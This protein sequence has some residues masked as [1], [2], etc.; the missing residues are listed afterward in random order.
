MFLKDNEDR[1]KK[2]NEST[3][4]AETLQLEI[5]QVTVTFS[6]LQ[7]M[8]NSSML[9]HHIRYIGIFSNSENRLSL[10]HAQVYGKCL[11]SSHWRLKRHC[12]AKW[13][14]NYM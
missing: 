10:L 9:K 14:E 5:A 12:S 4:A 1:N 8:Q 11:D 6:C 13:I 2:F 3:K 7:G